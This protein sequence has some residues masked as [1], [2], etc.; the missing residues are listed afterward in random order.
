MKKI[1]LI[2]ILIFVLSSCS[3]F[4]NKNNGSFTDLYQANVRSNIASLDE[5][6][7]LLGVN[8]H[9]SIVGAIRSGVS[10]PGI[11]SGSLSSDYV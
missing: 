6:L 8:R 9:E 7:V 5:L 1:I 3:F 4:Q 10:V 11:L 2:S